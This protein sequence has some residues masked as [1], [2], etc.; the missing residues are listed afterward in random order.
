MD[1]RWQATFSQ[2]GPDDAGLPS[3]EATESPSEAIAVPLLGPVSVS[4][5]LEP[6]PVAANA[7]K[8]A[9][10]RCGGR[11]WVWWALEPHPV[12]ATAP[13]AAAPPARRARRGPLIPF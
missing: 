11:V 8:A 10:A 13:K 1:D 3:P 9:A 4:L 7:T 6:Q 2:R 12:A 5:A